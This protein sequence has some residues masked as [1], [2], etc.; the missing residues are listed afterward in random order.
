[1]RVAT[2][3]TFV[4][5]VA[6]AAAHEARGEVSVSSERVLERR[7]AK[8]DW[9]P[10]VVIGVIASLIGIA[11]G[12]LIPWF[13]KAASSQAHAVDTL[14]YVLISISVPIFVLVATV[15]LFS[16]YRFRQRPGE[17]LLDGPPI[18]GNTRLEIVW[19][20]IP[21]MLLVGLCTY[22]FLVLHHV[23]KSG[24]DQLKVR[25]VGQ[26]FAWTFFYPG[27]NGKE[28]SSPELYLPRGRNVE[29]TL[30]SKD[31]IHDFWVPA[32]RIKKDIVPGID[33]R[34]SITPTVVGTYPI[35]CA[36]LCGLGHAAMRGTAHVMEPA[37]FSSFMRRLR[38]GGVAGAGGGSGAS[39]AP[40]PTNGKAI[41]TASGC[42]ACHTLAEAGSHGTVGPNLDT[43]LKGK[44]AAFIR[45]SIVDPNAVITPGYQPGIMPENFA[46]QLPPAQLNALVQ[47]L[48]SVTKGG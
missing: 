16:V 8:V 25:V 40:A 1:V 28:I 21:A 44:S 17:E 48:S 13:P 3:A 6:Y 22:A 14:W 5:S 46:Q 12:L 29:F 34:Y 35:V 43:G 26:Q 33:V 20:A 24:A 19:T 37:A 32:F 45:Q 10:M 2:I 15:V 31:V 38:A 36:E 42:T 11:A 18:H 7:R 30:Q 23:E 41:F 39:S 9:R 47:F 27:P 4:A